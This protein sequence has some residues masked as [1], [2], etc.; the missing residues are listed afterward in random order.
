MSKER[1]KFNVRAFVALMIT[2]VGL[3][4]IVT[5]IQNHAAEEAPAAEARE[6]GPGAHSLLAVLFVV[7]FVWHII[8]NRRVLWN[9]VKGS[10]GRVPA[11][12]REAIVAGIV[13]A[14]VV[15]VFVI[16]GLHAGG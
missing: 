1:K 9:H 3:G 13:V 11:I 8:L 2:F 14:L 10:A 16:H 4:L 5:G 15:G 6:A 7:F 12:S